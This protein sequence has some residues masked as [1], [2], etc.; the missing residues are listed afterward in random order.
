MAMDLHARRLIQS[1]LILGCALFSGC[2]WIPLQRSDSKLDSLQIPSPAANAV[3]HAPPPVPLDLT[4]SETQVSPKLQPLANSDQLAAEIPTA[5][6]LLDQAYTKAM[7]IQSAAFEEAHPIK[8][9]VRTVAVELTQP[10]MSP[11]TQPA[12]KVDPGIIQAVAPAPVLVK[13]KP[14]GAPPNSELASTLELPTTSPAVGTE[15][16]PAPERPHTPIPIPAL[17]AQSPDARWQDE[18]QTLLTLAREQ[19]VKENEKGQ[20]GLWSAREQLLARLTASDQSTW[21]TVLEALAEPTSAAE[22]TP[23]PSVE[24]ASPQPPAELPAQ[25]KLSVVSL[26]FC[27]KVDGFGNFEPLAAS[28]LKPGKPVGLYWEVEGLVAKSDATG[29]H[30]RLGSAIEVV[31]D[32]GTLV[33]SSHLGQAED[34]C[35]RPRR[36]YFV[37]TRLTL[38]ENL[39][40]G[41]YQ[42]RLKLEDL[43]GKHEATDV[44]SFTIV[45]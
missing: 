23:E 24:T 29:H 36:D 41:T 17:T 31:D 39:K 44:L 22:S 30:T 3:D 8:T 1:S 37:N 6:P 2:R 33:W 10:L 28:A 12:P 14:A 42:L 18:I 13:G 9:E 43:I 27:R 15:P 16:E 5:T 32:S 21:Q 38:P 7:A 25:P 19:A 45:P 40:P 4:G 34:S 11:A 35:R 26:A 20:P